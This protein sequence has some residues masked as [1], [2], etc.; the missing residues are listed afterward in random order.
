MYNNRARYYT[1][2]WRAHRRKRLEERGG[3]CENC[4]KGKSFFNPI[5]IHHIDGNFY[6]WS[7]ENEIVLCWRC[8]KIAQRNRKYI[9]KLIE[10]NKRLFGKKKEK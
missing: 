7:D 10:K 6:N 3:K 4:H 1:P 8:H 5:T 9:K 2:E